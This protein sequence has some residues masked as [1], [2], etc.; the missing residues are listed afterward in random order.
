MVGQPGQFG[1]RGPPGPPGSPGGR[2]PPGYEGKPL[3]AMIVLSAVQSSSQTFI[4]IPILFIDT[5][6]NA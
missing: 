2:G 5:S 3:L 1:P 4:H 6:N